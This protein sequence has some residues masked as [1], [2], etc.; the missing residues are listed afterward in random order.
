MNERID[1]DRC[2]E[3]LA[4]F[5]RGELEEREARAVA[6]HLRGC[7]ECR[8]ESA[9][10]ALLMEPGTDAPLSPAERS[11][12]ETSVMAAVST[13]KPDTE[14][15]VSLTQK[16]TPWGARMAQALGA[17]AVV[18]LIATFAY[19]GLAGGGDDSDGGADVASRSAA[20]VDDAEGKLSAQD[21]PV[22]EG[23]AADSAGGG[24]S[25][26][27]ESLEAAT[28]T[29]TAPNFKA[30]EPTF[31]IA[32]RLSANRL[33]KLGESGLGSVRFENAYRA[34][35]RDR[36]SNLL[37][38]LVDEAARVSGKE[39]AVQVEECATRVMETEDPVLPTF[40]L[41]G[42]LDDREVLVLGFSWTPR[43]S[44]PLDRY[45][46]WAWERGDC[47]VTVD[48]IDGRIRGSG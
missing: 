29:T 2:S 20:E 36:D 35:D 24:G 34:A 32:R 25:G 3:L 4:A 46:V 18:A 28:G 23:A 30:P 8:A 37:D 48:Y 43:R 47:D 15:V 10:A 31:A 22:A 16:R 39:D 17:A 42:T 12:I 9:A 13:A 6:D 41:V 14:N 27:T 21:E 44:G 1:H 26:T 40:G 11:R 5:H 38:I 19:L 45:M 7:D 33:E